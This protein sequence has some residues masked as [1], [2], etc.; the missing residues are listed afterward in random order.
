[1]TGQ[2]PARFVFRLFWSSAFVA[3]SSSILLTGCAETLPERVGLVPGAEDVEVIGDQPNRDIYEPIGGVTARV[4]STEVS[5]AVREAKNEL[6]NQAAKK[7]ATFVSIDEVTS[8]A[9]WDLRN[10]TVVSITGT[11]YR[12]K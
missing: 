7:G 9:S 5:A 1:M 12:L 11:A 3:L 4:M 10:K 6:R 2:E 8:R